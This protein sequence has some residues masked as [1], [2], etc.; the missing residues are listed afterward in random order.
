MGSNCFHENITK[1]TYH[2]HLE[3]VEETHQEQ[4]KEDLKRFRLQNMNQ[5]K[6]RAMEF[7]WNFMLKLSNVAT[8]S[9]RKKCKKS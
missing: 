8:T 1:G 4:Y 7:F 5:K 6:K 9:K 2:E 3:K